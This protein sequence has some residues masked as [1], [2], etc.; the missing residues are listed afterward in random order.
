MSA[1]R[2]R[3]FFVAIMSLLLYSCRHVSM[4]F[5]VSSQLDN[6]E[7]IMAH[8][9]ILQIGLIG[10][11]YLIV[12]GLIGYIFLIPYFS[13]K[14][15]NQRETLWNWVENHLTQ[16][17]IAAW[18]IGFITYFIGTFSGD[19]RKDWVYAVFSVVPMSCIHAC[20]M[21]LGQSD[22]SAIHGDRHNSVLYM[23]LFDISHFLAIMVSLC[24]VIKHFGYYV[25][26]RYKV[27]VEI[28]RKKTYS[29]IYLFWGVNDS[30]LHLA[31]DIIKKKEI[32]NVNDYLCIFVKTPFLEG[33]NDGYLGFNRLFNF[34]RLKD[35]ELR[36]LDELHN[37]LVVSSYHKLS[38]LELDEAMKVDILGQ[39][40]KLRKIVTLIERI[41][42]SGCQSDKSGLH[43]FFLGEERDVNI[44]ATINILKDINLDGK[45]LNIYCQA[46]KN[47]KTRWMEH[48]DIL[49]HNQHTHIHVIDTAH[50]SVMQLK[51]NAACHPVNFVNIDKHSGVPSIPYGALVVGFNE[52]GLEALKFLYEFGTF[53]N[54]DG[55]RIKGR[56]VAIDGNMDE[57]KGCFY[58]KAPAL[59][60]N[61]EIQLEK[62]RL[63]SE[64]YWKIV[65][66]LLPFLCQIV[67]AVGDDNLGINAAVDICSLAM[68]CRDKQNPRCLTIYV[69]SYDMDNYNRIRKVADD[70]NKSCQGM[71][72]SIVIFGY[73]DQIFSYDSIVKEKI[74]SE[75][76]KYNY[77]YEGSEGDIEQKWID[78][79][80]LGKDYYSMTDI[81]EVERKRDQNICNAL[82]RDTK[83]CILKQCT[84][85]EWPDKRIKLLLAQLEHERWVAYS[86]LNGWQLFPHDI[87]EKEQKTKDIYKKLHADICPW[88]Q[89][90]SWSKSQQLK[91]QGF[92]MKVVDTSILLE[93]QHISTK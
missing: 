38:V 85:I 49:H 63:G 61:D 46:R 51:D 37:C 76:K 80:G 92:D 28:C 75:A 86:K 33:E 91:T 32:D 8:S 74:I 93:N 48:Y 54:T 17:F 25:I 21:F 71:L 31:K 66:E 3:M 45:P 57:L 23:A 13:K 79:I 12:F 58:A 16:F 70:I 73:T 53:V 11:G 5:H 82:H 34:V 55:N 29:D 65:E 43:V 10:L 7:E 87:A 78:I 84:N 6:G 20:E 41:K 19:F 89:I 36:H 18:V 59:R 26:S 47:A 64:D 56:Y 50:L 15:H 22:I 14:T 40:L 81:E 90:R 9:D 27:W 68:R 69:R 44:N 39:Q 88:S 24:F 77:A 1:K 35:Q 72:I 83:M 60:S 62:C 42:A 30:S 52:T 4:D 67:I 2:I